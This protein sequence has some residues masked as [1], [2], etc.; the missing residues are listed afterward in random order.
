MFNPY[1]ST[2]FNK[3]QYKPTPIWPWGLVKHIV[4]FL[5]LELEYIFPPPLH[6][7]LTIDIITIFFFVF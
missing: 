4:I 1:N 5:S 2:L 3:T 7:Y 6:P